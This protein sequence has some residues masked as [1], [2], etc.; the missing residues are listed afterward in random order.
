VRP[1]EV[2]F[3]CRPASPRELPAARRGNLVDDIAVLESSEN[4]VLVMRE[5]SLLKRTLG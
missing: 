2:A 1:Y 3:S 5:G 4:V